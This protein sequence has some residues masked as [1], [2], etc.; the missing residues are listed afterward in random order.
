LTASPFEGV[1]LCGISTPF[2]MLS[3]ARRQITHVLLT[4]APLYRGRSPFSC[5]LHVLGAPL[6]FVL[7]Q[8]QT[9]QLNFRCLLRSSKALAK[10]LDPYGDDEL[11]T[12][13]LIAE[14]RHVSHRPDLVRFRKVTSARL[15]V[16]SRRHRAFREPT[17]DL[18]K[19]NVRFSFQGPRQFALR[20]SALGGASYSRTT[21]G[22]RSF[23][24][25]GRSLFQGREPAFSRVGRRANPRAPGP[26]SVRGRSA[27]GPSPTGLSSCAR[28]RRLGHGGGCAAAAVGGGAPGAAA[29]ATWGAAATV[30]RSTPPRL[31]FVTCR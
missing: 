7:S 29:G 12:A 8:D 14:G 11:V 13:F 20:R 31:P 5:D 23:F 19:V 4:R 2:G 6:T 17:L 24:V 22:Q 21:F 9:L 16:M 1:V 26:R 27:P 28:W 25:G 30:A 10:D 18:S 3:P 15:L